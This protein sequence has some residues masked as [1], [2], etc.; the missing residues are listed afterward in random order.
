MALC[1]YV[2]FLCTMFSSSSID[3]IVC[4]ASNFDF[5]SVTKDNEM[6]MLKV[7][8]AHIKFDYNRSN[9][10]V[11]RNPE[12]S[13]VNLFLGNTSYSYESR[14]DKKRSSMF[15]FRRNQKEITPVRSE[16]EIIGSANLVDA[17]NISKG[18]ENCQFKLADTLT[19]RLLTSQAD[20]AALKCLNS[21]LCQAIGPVKEEDLARAQANP[22]KFGA[23]L[24][25][26]TS[27]TEHL[28]DAVDSLLKKFP[29]NVHNEMNTTIELAD[30][31]YEKLLASN[32]F[33][34]FLSG[35]QR[36]GNVSVDTS[37]SQGSTLVS[38]TFVASKGYLI[39]KHLEVFKWIPFSCSACADIQNMIFRAVIV[40]KHDKNQCQINVQEIDLIFPGLTKTYSCNP[41][42]YLSDVS[43]SLYIGDAMSSAEV[44]NSI[45]SH[46]RKQF[47]E[48][49]KALDCESL[50]PSKYH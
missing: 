16:T 41:H 1:S 29:G 15:S 47:S 25:D 23:V 24:A 31:K 42:T 33:F 11:F 7:N 10:R 26:T 35:L 40:L 5:V 20:E 49:V 32:G 38:F 6:R 50:I 48:Y 46:I 34:T 43:V 19:G 37:F 27:K 30:T 9:L 2:S 45:E 12:M 36:E 21:M 17:N 18:L 13:S 39:Y 4:P 8:D 14:S 28:V 22:L 3:S 44:A